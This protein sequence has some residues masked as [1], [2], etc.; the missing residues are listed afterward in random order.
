MLAMMGIIAAFTVPS[1]LNS[2]NSNLASKQSAMAKDAA[3][4]IFTAYRQYKMTVGTVPT[5]ATALNLTPYMNYLSMDTSGKVIDGTPPVSSSTCNSTYPCLK[6]HNGGYLWLDASNY[7]NGS[8]TL[9]VI[10]FRFDPDANNNTTASVDGPTKAV[11]FDLYYDGS[12]TTRGRAK[13]NSTNSA[14]GSFS[15][16][17][18]FD[19]SWFSGL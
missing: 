15:G 7:F 2:Q 18:A 19:P 13:T 5:T 16:S 14:N 17:A 9:N 3:F 8:T 4:M 1:M 6:L 10:E 11:Q 12:I